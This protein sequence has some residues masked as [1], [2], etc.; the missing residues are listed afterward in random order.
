M[1]FDNDGK[2]RP[3]DDRDGLAASAFRASYQI[4]NATLFTD[5]LS[6]LPEFT[7]TGRA[8][9]E[10][11]FVWLAP[12][13]GLGTQPGRPVATIRLSAQMLEIR[14]DSRKGIQA[15]RVLIEELGGKK[16]RLLSNTSSPVSSDFRHN[17]PQ[18]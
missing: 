8:G 4:Q 10:E 1:E 7:R 5:A 9:P 16:V 6:R 3:E 11:E 17:E 14:S 2:G 15:L 13:H 12:V 18:S